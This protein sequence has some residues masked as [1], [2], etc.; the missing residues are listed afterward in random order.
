MPRQ[1][2]LL[3]SICQYVVKR[4]IYVISQKFVADLILLKKLGSCSFATTVFCYRRA[5]LLSGK[6][7]F[8]V[9]GV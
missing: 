9:T 4:M 3:P 7:D 2:F 6:D 8:G 1:C 5:V